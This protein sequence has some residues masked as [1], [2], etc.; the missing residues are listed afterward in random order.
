MLGQVGSACD[1]IDFNND[2]LFPDTQDIADFI[3]V[4]GGGVC[5]GQQVGDPPCNSD[6]DFN[7]D[8]L[9]PDTDD[10]GALLRVFG[11]GG[12]AV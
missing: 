5:G 10:I 6:I 11:G 1:P 12:C 3:A 7:N 4:F 2:S 9:F 8:G